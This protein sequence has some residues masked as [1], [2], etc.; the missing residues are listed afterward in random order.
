MEMN[1]IQND[2]LLERAKLAVLSR[3][4]DSAIRIY[5]GLLKS[6]P[7]NMELLTELGGLYI[8][9]GND[10][11]ALNVY[12]EIAR[13][14]PKSVSALNS[15]G[16]IY[17]R[18][19]MYDESI[20]VLEKAAML[21]SENSQVYYN[22]G[23]T[24]RLMGQ[25]DDAIQCFNTVVES[26]SND[27]L[28]YNHLGAI[29]A[30][31]KKYSDAVNSYLRGLKVDPNHPI[32]HL[33][34]A[35]CYDE[36]DEFEKA[37]NEYE[38]ALKTKPGWLE[39]IV[40]YADLLLKFNKTRAAGELVKKALVLNSKNS[41]VFSKFG[42]VCYRQGDYKNAE[43]HYNE[44]LDLRQESKRALMG[45][46]RTY[47]KSER[48]DESL[49][50]MS[51]I[52]DL[53]PE[54]IDVQKQYSHILLTAE[55]LQE[56][57]E[58][59][60][61]LYEKNQKD[62]ETLDLLGQYYICSGEE[63]KAFACYKRIKGIEPKYSEFY[64]NGARRYGQKNN[65]AKAEEFY[66]RYAD[67]NPQSVECYELMAENYEK[68]NKLDQALGSFRKVMNL[69]QD[70]ISSKT[71]IDR[72]SESIISKGSEKFLQKSDF[73][74][75]ESYDDDISLSPSS[76]PEQSPVEQEPVNDEPHYA[77]EPQP[78][79]EIRSMEDYDKDFSLLTE[80]GVPDEDI[81]DNGKL[82]ET[83]EADNQQVYKQ[84]LD[85]LVGEDDSRDENSVGLIEDNMD[86][87]DFF[88]DNTFGRQHKNNTV[89][90]AHSFEA[91]FEDEDVR[92]NDRDDDV[93]SLDEEEVKPA[94]KPREPVAEKTEEDDFS[95]EDED[96]E[97]D[98]EKVEEYRRE[99][100]KKE[101]KEDYN[102]DIFS[103]PVAEF[104][105]RNKQLDNDMLEQAVESIGELEAR[106][107]ELAEE[108]NRDPMDE[109]LLNDE[110]VEEAAEDEI[111]EEDPVEET[112][113]EETVEAQVEEMDAEE[114]VE[115]TVREE[116]VDPETALFLKL[117]NLIEFLPDEKRREFKE[118]KTS[119]QLDFIISRLAGRK[120]LLVKAEDVHDDENSS[121]YVEKETGKALLMKTLSLSKS[122]AEN[123]KD[124]E[125]IT[126]MN[127]QIDSL[128][129]KL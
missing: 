8:K 91:E 67:A 29:Y 2:S 76:Q 70:N 60:R 39:A 21:D 43:V 10:G 28:A 53:Y 116:D 94:R 95:F 32:L 125:L 71:A 65:F 59:I 40:D 99:P 4:F 38:T 78:E 68:Q 103:K 44:A 1:S 45:L 34:L 80:E 124:E 52:E 61:R 128:M 112:V 113:E 93:R 25:Y 12:K 35:K 97:F 90:D 63:K 87:D 86:A 54:D 92:R 102:P 74:E 110:A 101:K 117:K 122:L 31:Q 72:I 107:D 111:I 58:R 16:G 79:E 13:L 106:L 24:Y 88:A 77:E 3:D 47:A 56:A 120:G 85:D 109:L 36:M 14:D 18:L 66:E 81:F 84:S 96:L 100:E 48:L 115:E 6:N 19:K 27:V 126:S 89:E 20:A 73:D 104:A 82:D 62:L 15:L 7:E 75:F 118:S 83:V 64:M 129:K 51:R 46:A 42:D 37:K 57:S 69:D 33:N 123:L 50:V 119:L 23:F 121:G 127:T 9:S 114:P 108:K 22:M 55:L 105:Q 5:K 17:R 41:H 26:N 30:R 49:G 98:A 11:D